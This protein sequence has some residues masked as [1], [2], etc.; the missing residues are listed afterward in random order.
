MDIKNFYEVFPTIKLDGLLH[1]LF[2]HV[3]VVRVSATSDRTVMRIYLS[4]ENLITYRQLSDVR[5]R[6]RRQFGEKGP[7][8]RIYPKFNLSAQYD[9]SKLYGIYRDSI[10]DEVND[11]G[12]VL[13]DILSNARI[14]FPEGD[15]MNITLE[16]GVYPQ[17]TVSELEDFLL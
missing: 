13:F 4:S 5:D 9:L 12:H 1:D 7:E 10:F 3:D 16:E 14:D 11:R 15:T 6:I 17:K 2:E 8:I